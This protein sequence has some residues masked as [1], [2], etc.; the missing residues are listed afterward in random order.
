MNSVFNVKTITAWRRGKQRGF[1]PAV[2]LAG[3]DKIV[4][5]FIVSAFT[6]LIYSWAH[7]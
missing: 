1:I 3:L 5:E 6:V 7:E 2:D 4:R